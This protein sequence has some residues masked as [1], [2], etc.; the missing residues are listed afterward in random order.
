MLG[1][2][3]IGVNKVG[4][5]LVIKKEKKE[6]ELFLKENNSKSGDLVNGQ[7]SDFNN[8]KSNYVAVLEIPKIELE[9]GLV[10]INSEDNDVSKNIQV[11]ESSIFP[12][13]EVGNLYLAGHSGDGKNAY[14]KD[15]DKLEIGDYIYLYYYGGRYDYYVYDIYNIP[16]T[17]AVVVDRKESNNLYMIT[18]SY[19]NDNEQLLVRA[20][21]IGNK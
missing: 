17:G 11:L 21:I 18:C 7:E 12:V 8:N 1:I 14:F 16:K 9:R 10:S 4:D 3:I 20:K 2:I 6:V 19:E 15:L 13:T 5:Y